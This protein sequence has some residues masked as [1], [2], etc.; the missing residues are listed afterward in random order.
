MKI[1]FAKT[2]I[3][4]F[5]KKSLAPNNG[6]PEPT[7]IVAGIPPQTIQEFAS[8]RKSTPAKEREN[9]RRH[10]EARD[11]SEEKRLSKLLLAVA[12]KVTAARSSSLVR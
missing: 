9:Y 12:T 3:N 8:W 1:K 5:G 11:S 7:G 6:T 4:I 2:G 10:L